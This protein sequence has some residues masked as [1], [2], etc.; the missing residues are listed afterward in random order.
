[1]VL[2]C[3][4]STK[5]TIHLEMEYLAAFSQCR[6]STDSGA[7]LIHVSASAFYHIGNT[8]ASLVHIGEGV[9]EVAGEETTINPSR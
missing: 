7:R 2:R 9:G 3:G 5:A 1:M 4:G 6:R 8:S